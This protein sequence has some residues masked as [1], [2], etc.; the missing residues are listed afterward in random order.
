MACNESETNEERSY[1]VSPKKYWCAGESR[2]LY[3]WC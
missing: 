3:S 2:M 1:M